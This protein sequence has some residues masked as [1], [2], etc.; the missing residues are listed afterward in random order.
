ME[1]DHSLLK[2]ARAQG[3]GTQ[4][5]LSISTSLSFSFLLMLHSWPW[6]GGGAVQQVDDGVGWLTVVIVVVTTTTNIQLATKYG[7]KSL[8]AFPPKLGPFSKSAEML[9]KRQ[10]GLMAFLNV[11]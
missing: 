10:D 7:E 2:D 1:G 9:V 6:G 5:Y 4:T 8:P 3:E 11:R